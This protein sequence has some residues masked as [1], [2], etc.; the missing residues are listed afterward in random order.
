MP[1]F[2]SAR[3]FMVLSAGVDNA[4]SDGETWE[5]GGCAWTDV[6]LQA[7][8]TP[9]RRYAMAYDSARGVTVLFGRQRLA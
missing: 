1:Q 3:G 4:A 8:P 2:D 7:E 9:R 5:G 6:S